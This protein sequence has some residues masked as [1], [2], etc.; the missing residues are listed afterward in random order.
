M[1]GYLNCRW[2][3][4]WGCLA[5]ESEQ[6][7]A[8]HEEE[9]IF[10]A[11]PLKPEDMEALCRVAGREALEH[12]FGPNGQG[13]YEIRMLAAVEHLKRVMRAAEH[14]PKDVS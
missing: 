1:S 4:G 5:C 13:I 9:P 12:A 14:T 8:Q 10:V 3:R 6:K 7:R 2:C 11:D